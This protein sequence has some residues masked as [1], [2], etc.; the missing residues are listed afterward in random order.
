MVNL[1]NG[2]TVFRIFMVPLV[3][4]LIIAGNMQ[5]AFFVFVAAGLSD[6]L[7]GYL[8]K[9][10]GSKTVLGA[11]LDPIADKALLVSIFLTL[12]YFGHLPVWLVIAVVSRDLLIVG[13]FILSWILAHPID[14]KPLYVSKAN[15]VSQIVLAALALA[16]QGFGLGLA[17]L[18]TVLVWITGGLTI[19]SAA[20]YLVTWLRHMAASEPVG[21]GK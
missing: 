13:A 21:P 6:A 19:V 15:T 9:R 17:A 20:A 5:L 4:W 2:I 10:F 16:D 3:V 18:V 1:P 14:L 7:D 8:A 11:Y 12:G